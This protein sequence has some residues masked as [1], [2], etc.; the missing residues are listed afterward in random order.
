MWLVSVGSVGMFVI[1]TLKNS[2]NLVVFTS[3]DCNDDMWE[4]ATNSFI[5][6]NQTVCKSAMFWLFKAAFASFCSLHVTVLQ[7]NHHCILVWTSLMKTVMSSLS[8]LLVIFPILFDIFHVR[9]AQFLY[10][11]KQGWAIYGYY[12]NILSWDYK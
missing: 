8:N 2:L 4:A 6:D 10:K 7:R 11:P 12:I 3:I 5:Y 9:E 1:I